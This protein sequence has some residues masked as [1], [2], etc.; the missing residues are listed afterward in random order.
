MAAV[1]ALRSAQGSTQV[2]VG[3]IQ[4]ADSAESDDW[5]ADAMS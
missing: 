2:H 3:P 4:A 1:W 5:I